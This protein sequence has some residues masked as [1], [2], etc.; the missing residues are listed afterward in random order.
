MPRFAIAVLAAVILISF[1]ARARADAYT[2]KATAVYVLE[3][4]TDDSDEQADALTQALR[5]RVRATP[6][7][8]LLETQQSLEKLSVILHCPPKPDAPC[9]QRIGD[10]I[11][12]DRYVWGTMAKKGP[13]QIGVE[14]HL[15]ARGKP[16]MKTEQ[17]VSDNLKDPSDDALKKVAADLFANVSG[18]VTTGSVTVHAGAGGGMVLV[19]GAERAR[20]DNGTT[21][22]DV[23]VGTHT[24]EVRADGNQPWTQQITVVAGG[25][26]DVTATLVP[27]GGGAMPPPE[28]PSKPLPIR[29]IAGFTLV[30]AGVIVAAVGVVGA[31][32]FLGDKSDLDNDRANIPASVP[33][34][35]AAKETLVEISACNSY[36]SAHSD[37]SLELVG[38]GVGAVLI[39]GGLVV[40]FTGHDAESSPPT[41]GQL[42]LSPLLSPK[43]GGMAASI[44]F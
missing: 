26:Q 32:K 7:W 18:A 13:H 37:R 36:N 17:V 43:L 16:D 40:L 42:H 29:K 38:L 5:A 2:P 6:G 34:A 12:A 9:L 24:L 3:I 20:L 19:D 39:A 14:L 25:D 22:L 28:P 11:K 27:L 30:G 4:L 8:T 21:K 10:T 1:G 41:A 35:C 33:D 15:W 31:V 44:T 23:A